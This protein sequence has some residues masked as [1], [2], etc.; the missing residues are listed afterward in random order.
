MKRV[1]GD[2]PESTA[3][4]G[5]GDAPSVVAA[6]AGDESSSGAPAARRR[7]VTV[8]ESTVPVVVAVNEE[9]EE[10]VAPAADLQNPHAGRQVIA[11]APDDDE[12]DAGQ[13]RDSI[14]YLYEEAR[15]E[16]IPFK[17]E[18]SD[19]GTEVWSCSCRSPLLILL[20]T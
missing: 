5:Y 3:V 8:A 19:D 6:V 9:A 15:K 4:G 11:V 20:L 13:D 7:A 14:D 10:V 1:R 12:Y 18:A 16:G 17:E 2:E